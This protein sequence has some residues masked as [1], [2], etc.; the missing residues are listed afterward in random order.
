MSALQGILRDILA[1]ILGRCN[2]ENTESNQLTQ[3]LDLPSD[4]LPL[5]IGQ[6]RWS[7]RRT[8]R[9]LLDYQNAGRTSLKLRWGKDD[10]AS[11]ERL[12]GL[13]VQL[14]RLAALQ[15]VDTTRRV[16]DI[17]PIAAVGHHLQSLELY[18]FSELEDISP[19]GTCSQLSSLKI[20][21]TMS[22]IAHPRIVDL[23]PL[24]SCKL[25]TQVD[26]SE[27]HYLLSDL[28]PLAECVHIKSLHL[29]YLTSVSDLSPLSSLVDLT[30]LRMGSLRLQHID[31]LAACSRLTNLTLATFDRN[32][33][34]TP[35]ASCQQLRSLCICSSCIGA[36]LLPLMQCAL[37][38]ELS[39][40]GCDRL[41]DVT[42]LQNLPELR[43]L[44]LS[45]CPAMADISPLSH[46]KALQRLVI[47]QCRV[48]D[49]S[50]RILKAARP[51]LS[52]S[53]R[54]QGPRGCFNCFYIRQ[55]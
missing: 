31:A 38:T 51:T 5:I 54:P 41:S 30:T 48:S 32:P 9:A 35:L 24:S 10:P 25:L 45:H 15:C 13:L 4:L 27:C 7:A 34:L 47:V 53:T 55:G 22:D 8:C 19:I 18:N 44:R 21:G 3:L 52:I 11:S 49:K 20:S 40:V 37:L 26:L 39:L 14:P 17:S 42:S 2:T 23:C 29:S 33:P 43:V 50:I 36:D 46:C 6:T 16:C 28:G 12:A 1:H